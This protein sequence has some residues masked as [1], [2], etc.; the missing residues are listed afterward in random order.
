MALG[1]NAGPFASTTANFT[2]EGGSYGITRVGD[3]GGG[4]VTLNFQAPNGAWVPALAAWT[5]NGFAIQS[6]P[7]GTYQLAVASTATSTYVSI[8]RIPRQ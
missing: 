6:L 8:S 4:T 5:A 3:W 2:L 1:Y 7:G